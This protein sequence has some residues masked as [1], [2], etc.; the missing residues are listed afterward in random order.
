MKICVFGSEGRMGRLVRADAGDSVSACYDRNDFDGDSFEPLSPDVQVVIDFSSPEAWKD[1]DRLLEGSSAA[2]VTGTTGLEEPQ[3]EMLRRWSR[4]RAVFRASNFSFGVF[5]LGRLL[6]SAALMTGC[7]PDLEI[8]ECH[9]GGKVDSP[10]GTALTLAGI[11]KDLCSN[12]E[13]VFGRRGRAGPRSRGEI[14]IHSVRGGDVTGDHS[15]H[16]LMQGESI[17]LSHRATGRRTFSLG[18]LRAAE[19]IAEK[20]PGI[21]SMKDLAK[22]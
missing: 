6:R 5:V 13:Y 18:A 7:D 14:G 17:T 3:M 16:L 20:P 19:F 2:L 21:Y 1:L 4:T 11:W 8:V 22:E 9:H 10:S 15:L 12:S